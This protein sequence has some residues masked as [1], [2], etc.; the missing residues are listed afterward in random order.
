MY[1]EVYDVP[2]YSIH[3]AV[4]IDC[5]STCKASAASVLIEDFVPGMSDACVPKSGIEGTVQYSKCR[6]I[7]VLVEVFCARDERG[8]YQK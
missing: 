4:S 8:G 5:C 6:T 7:S 2:Q 1:S 3:Q